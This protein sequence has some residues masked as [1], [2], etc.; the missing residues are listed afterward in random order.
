LYPAKLILLHATTDDEV[1][2]GVGEGRKKPGK[3]GCGMEKEC[4]G[5]F[6]TEGTMW[7]EVFS[8]DYREAE[9]AG[10]YLEWCEKEKEYRNESVGVRRRKSTEGYMYM[11]KGV[12][13]RKSARGDGMGVGWRKS[14]E[15]KV[16]GRVIGEFGTEGIECMWL[17]VF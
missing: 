6:E 10:R 3:V 1:E 17:G 7:V 9:R 13:R 4:V 11:R 8:D 2:C 14:T 15:G 16:C 5:E 12:G